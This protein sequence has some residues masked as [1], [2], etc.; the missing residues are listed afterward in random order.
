MLDDD[1]LSLLTALRD[2]GNPI[3]VSDPTM[4]FVKVV[5]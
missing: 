3:S 4:E 5:R 1:V 2:A